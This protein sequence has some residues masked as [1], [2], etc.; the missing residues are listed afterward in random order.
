MALCFPLTL[1]YADSRT[2][3]V[4]KICGGEIIKTKPVMMVRMVS[5]ELSLH[6]V[7]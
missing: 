6:S 3:I 7:L 1:L 2:A 5:G 4:T